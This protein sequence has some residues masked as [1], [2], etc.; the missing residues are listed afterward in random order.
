M[1]KA[2]KTPETL[3]VVKLEIGQLSCC[4]RGT[5]PLIFNCMSE[6]VRGHLLFPPAK[7]T[8]ADRAMTMKHDPLTEYRDSIYA[9]ITN[10]HPT[11]LFFPAGSFKRAMASAAIDLPGLKKAQIGRLV[12]IDAKDID[13]YGVPQM[14]M[15]VVRSADM[16]RTPDIRTR[17]VVSEWACRISISYVRHLIKERDLGN[18]L[19]AA[20]L[21][22]GVGDWRQEKGSGSFGQFSVVDPDDANFE[23]IVK[24]GGREAQDAALQRP[25]YFDLETEKLMTWFENEVQRRGPDQAASDKPKRRGTLRVPAHGNGD[26]R[27][28]A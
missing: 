5:T 11:R 20:G 21:I 28:E 3:S 26:A 19:A 27:A 4:I 15:S 22:I 1:S 9:H 8:A 17:A 14:L 10:D 16:N 12:W 18:L 7:K 25:S 23:A 6:K 2:E 13:V 24:H